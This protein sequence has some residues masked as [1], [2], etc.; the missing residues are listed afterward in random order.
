[1]RPGER[2]ELAHAG[3]APVDLDRRRTAV[4]GLVVD[5]AGNVGHAVGLAPADLVVDDQHA[6]VAAAAREGG[7]AVGVVG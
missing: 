5:E 2:H 1:V 7:A 6:A 3:A 4:R